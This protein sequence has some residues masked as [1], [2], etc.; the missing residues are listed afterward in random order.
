MGQDK[1]DLQ[2]GMKGG[3]ILRTFQ[4]DFFA[5]LDCWLWNRSNRYSFYCSP[6]NYTK[7][8]VQS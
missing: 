4:V 3:K 1:E 7:Q 8:I 2:A 6:E 5:F